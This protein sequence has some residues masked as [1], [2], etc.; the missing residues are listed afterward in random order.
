[1]DG[2][3]T[4]DGASTESLSHFS[5]HAALHELSLG[6]L[7]AVRRR[8]DAQ[9]R[10]EHGLGCRALVDT[11][12]AALPLGDHARTPRDVPEHRARSPP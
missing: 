9:L 8:Y 5:W 3:V 7:D 4:G 12:L 11:R 6:D 1:M 2:W 10:P